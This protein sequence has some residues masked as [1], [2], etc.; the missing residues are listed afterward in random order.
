MVVRNIWGNV[1]AVSLMNQGFINRL[2]GLYSLY[3]LHATVK[4]EIANATYTTGIE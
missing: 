3:I 1:K 2:N 4:S